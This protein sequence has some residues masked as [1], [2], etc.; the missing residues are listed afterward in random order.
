MSSPPRT[1]EGVEHGCWLQQIIPLL[2]EGQEDTDCPDDREA[3]A[4][5]GNGCSWNAVFCQRGRKTTKNDTVCTFWACCHQL[6]GRCSN[7]LWEICASLM[8]GRG[9]F[10]ELFPSSV[11]RASI[12]HVSFEC[13]GYKSR[14]GREKR[15]L[16]ILWDS[17]GPLC[18]SAHLY[19]AAGA[20]WL[21]HG[22]VIVKT[23]LGSMLSSLPSPHTPLLEQRD[24]SLLLLFH[25][26]Q[27]ALAWCWCCP[28]AREPSAWA[29][30]AQ[31]P[32]LECSAQLIFIPLPLQHW[33]PALWKHSF[34]R[35]WG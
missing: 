12:G 27:K 17:P 14:A 15:F 4:E 18:S 13:G 7:S 30:Q 29:Q 10:G 8:L 1:C 16:N 3:D 19:G 25:S 28:S 33:F 22:N 32:W 6:W 20:A 34:F 24:S 26:A 31:Q 35:A 9:G 23:L 5:D 2:P 11:N 21:C